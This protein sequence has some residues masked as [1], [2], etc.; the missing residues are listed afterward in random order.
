V[1]E[2]C[3]VQGGGDGWGAIAYS[4]VRW[5]GVAGLSSRTGPEP[6]AP[7]AQMEPGRLFVL[8]AAMTKGGHE[9]LTRKRYAFSALM[10]IIDPEAEGSAKASAGAAGAS[11]DATASGGG[12]G[13]VSGGGGVCASASG[14]SDCGSDGS[15]EDAAV[16][17]AR[18][19]V[20]CAAKKYLDDYKEKAFKAALIEPLKLYVAARGGGE[21]DVGNAVVHGGNTFSALLVST[22]AIQL[23]MHPYLD[24]NHANGEGGGWSGGQAVD[25]AIV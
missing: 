11:D 5:C 21:V 13:S 7:D 10:D 4:L 12:G 9:C 16:A 3:E 25:R 1:L 20:Q 15:V 22:L 6:T 2:R 14:G 17:Q 23:P 19:A 24:D 8:L 18:C